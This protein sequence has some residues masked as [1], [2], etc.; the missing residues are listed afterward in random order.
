MPAEPKSKQVSRELQLSGIQHFA[1]SFVLPRMTP[2]PL[3]WEHKE[4][5]STPLK[6]V[7]FDIGN[8]LLFPDRRHILKPLGERDVSLEHWHTVERETKPKFDDIVEHGGPPDHGFW[9]MFYAQ[10]LKDLQI[11]DNQVH[12]ALVNAT[13][14]SANWC[15]IRPTTCDALRRI[16]KRYPLGIISNADGKVSSVLERTGIAA[17]V[18][19]ITDSGVIG[20]E[21]PHPAIFEA[22]LRTLNADPEQS[23]YVGDVYSV[24]Y[25]GATRAGMQAVLFDVS[26]AYRGRGLPRVE[27]L[28]ELEQRLA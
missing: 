14:I 10:L 16:G 24:D 4:S 28:E 9:H 6:T 12:A 1:A 27:S 2:G 8:T 13:R 15:D 19:T 26:G 22:A 3:S 25:L 17:C 7:F 18:Q 11:D 5:M 21:K 23:L 20:Y